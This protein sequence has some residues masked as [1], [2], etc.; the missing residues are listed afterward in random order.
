[1]EDGMGR[2]YSIHGRKEDCIQGFGERP[3]REPYEDIDG[4]ITLKW[5][6]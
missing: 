4:R 1:M 6:L 3:E 2:A 5:I